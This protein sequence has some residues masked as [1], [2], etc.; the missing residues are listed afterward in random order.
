M[1]AGLKKAIKDSIKHWKKD[2]LKPLLE[3]KEIT[4]YLYHPRWKDSRRIVRCYGQ[5]CPLCKYV[6]EDCKLCPIPQYQRK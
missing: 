4:E 3:G 1:E 2:I 5:H 6:K